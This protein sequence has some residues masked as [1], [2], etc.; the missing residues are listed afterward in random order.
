IFRKMIASNKNSRRSFIKCNAMG[1]AGLIF[2]A[3]IIGNRMDSLNIGGNSR[4]QYVLPKY[5]NG[6]ED[7]PSDIFGDLNLIR[8]GTQD[9]T[10]GRGDTNIE[11]IN[12]LEDWRIKIK[13]LKRLYLSTLGVQPDGLE[14]D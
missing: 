10:I 11:P 14:C 13:H 12:S 7:V 2:G 9:M 6:K 5:F 3:D 8:K 1:Y 4:N